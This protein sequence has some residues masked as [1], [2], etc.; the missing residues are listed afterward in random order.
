MPW[1]RRH[2]RLIGS[3]IDVEDGQSEGSV[4]DVNSAASDSEHTEEELATLNDGSGRA[5]YCGYWSARCSACGRMTHDTG[6]F[7]VLFY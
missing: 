6:L 4:P 1:P 3:F 5:S 2:G 7:S